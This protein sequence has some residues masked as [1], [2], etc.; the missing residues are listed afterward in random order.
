M[1][2]SLRSMFVGMTLLVVVFAVVGREFYLYRMAAYHR[3]GW[4]RCLTLIRAETPH[5]EKFSTCQ[6]W[7]AYHQ[8]MDNEYRKAMLFPLMPVPKTP[9]SS[10]DP[11]APAPNPPKP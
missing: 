4:H 3:H 7:L 8:G 5:S 11:S 9:P 10:P 1:K 6:R 2:Y